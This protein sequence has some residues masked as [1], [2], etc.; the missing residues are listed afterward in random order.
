MASTSIAGEEAHHRPDEP[1]DAEKIEN[2]RA[3][4]SR[5]HH[6]IRHRR[7]ALHLRI[8]ASPGR[9]IKFDMQRCEGYRNFCNKL[10]N[11]RA[12]ADELRRQGC[13]AR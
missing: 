7:F 13:R 12:S 2:A 5:K 9:D 3:A 11:A 6:R 4:N 8:I 1:K 10:W